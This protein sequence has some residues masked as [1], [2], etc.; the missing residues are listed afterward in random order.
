[1]ERWCGD[2]RHKE[3]S[4][5]PARIYRGVFRF[6]FTWL[7][8]VILVSNVPAKILARPFESP[9]SGL[10]TLAVATVFILAATRALWLVALRRYGSASS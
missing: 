10:A 8:P 4:H 7:V 9:W 3:V 6:I 5:E 2:E 1:M